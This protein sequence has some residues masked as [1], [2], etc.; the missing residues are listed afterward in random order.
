MQLQLPAPFIKAGN[1]NHGV[2]MEMTVI[3]SVVLAQA[4]HSGP[5]TPP[6][7]L[8]AAALIICLENASTPRMACMLVWRWRGQGFDGKGVAFKNLKTHFASCKLYPS[9]G[10]RTPNEQVEGNFGQK[11]FRF[12]IV[13][14][15]KV[16][17]CVKLFN[18]TRMRVLPSRKRNCACG[19]SSITSPSPPSPSSTIRPQ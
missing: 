5:P 18:T 6:A 19:K 16:A 7:M 9:V 12:D 17:F 2:I 3:R 13:Q 10:L 4:N 8:S 14:Y 1:Q 11:P 15:I